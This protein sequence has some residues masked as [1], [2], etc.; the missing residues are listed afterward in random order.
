MNKRV[1]ERVKEQKRCLPGG[2]SN[3][4]HLSTSRGYLPLYCRGLLQDGCGAASLPH[5]TRGMIVCDPQVVQNVVHV[6]VSGVMGTWYFMHSHQ[7]EDPT[8]PCLR[9]ALTTSLGSVCLGSLGIAPVKTLEVIARSALACRPHATASFWIGFLA[10]C[11]L[12]RR[13]VLVGQLRGLGNWRAP[14]DCRRPIMAQL[15][16]AEAQGH[17][18]VAEGRILCGLPFHRAG[19]SSARCVLVSKR[20]ERGLGTSSPKVSILGMRS[21]GGKWMQEVGGR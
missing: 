13:D 9:R 17:G 14:T 3:P 15:S 8:T 21:S 2:D 7:T 20:H 1:K 6:A 19:M 18:N 16:T 12:V 4:G 5:P 11:F 10:R